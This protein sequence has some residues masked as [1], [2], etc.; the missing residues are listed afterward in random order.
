MTL[1]GV[2][3][4]VENP[5]SE[6]F[7]AISGIAESLMPASGSLISLFIPSTNRYATP[8]QPANATLRETE[9]EYNGDVRQ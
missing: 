4:I 6:P 8:P 1:Q 5:L 9:Q 2:F 3:T 7:P